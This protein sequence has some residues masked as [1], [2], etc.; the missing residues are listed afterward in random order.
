[1]GV[2]GHQTL[3]CPRLGWVR[4]RERGA[5]R[6]DSGGWPAWTAGVFEAKNSMVLVAGVS[7]RCVRQGV[8]AGDITD[9]IGVD[10]TV[11]GDLTMV[12]E[13]AIIVG[14]RVW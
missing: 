13:S 3:G 2:P 1:M 12:V 8:D 9:V 14:S 11:A 5:D 10:T 4:N 6:E 7:V